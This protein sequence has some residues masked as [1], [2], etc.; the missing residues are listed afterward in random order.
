MCLSGHHASRHQML[1]CRQTRCWGKSLSPSYNSV[2][3]AERPICEGNRMGA[4]G[5]RRSQ[6]DLALRLFAIT[7][8]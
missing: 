2:R 1:T 3:I 4:D 5:F 7:K 6:F 8:Q